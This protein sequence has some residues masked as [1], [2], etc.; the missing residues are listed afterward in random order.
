MK[1]RGSRLRRGGAL[2]RSLFRGQERDADLRANVRAFVDLLTDEKI[3]AG[4]TPEAARRAAILEC[5]SVDV[6][7]ENVRDVRAGALVAQVRQDARFALRILRCE[8][9]F[10]A[11]VILTLALGI[12]ANTAIFSV[13]NAVLLEPLPYPNAERLVLVWERNT[14][15][16][17]DR[18]PV[19][20]LNFQ[21]WRRS[22]TVFDELAAYRFRGVA[23]TH[24]EQPEQLQALSTTASLFRVLG[25]APALGRAFTDDEE[26]RRE[27][28]AVLSHAF[29]QR[30][31]GGDPSVVGR[32]VALDGAAFTIVGVMPAAF[33]FPDDTP[34][35]VDLYSPVAF[36]PRELNGR[37]V[38]TLTVMARLKPGVT[39]HAAQANIGTIATSIAAHDSTG[40]PEVAIVGAHDALVEDVRLGLLT[41]LGTVG[42]VLLV[43]CANVANLLLVRA[44]ARRRELAMRAALGAGNRRLLQQVLTESLV[45]AGLGAGVGLA[46]A[47][48]LLRMLVS[49]APPDL[50]RLERIA[51]DPTVLVFT[52]AVAIVT[53]VAFG[54]VP[55]LAAS[56]RSLTDVFKPGSPH[57]TATFGTSNGRTVLLVGEIALSL[58]LLAGA[59]LMV[60]SLINL[61]N[62]ELGLE[63]ANVLTAQIFLAPSRYPVDS[64][65][66]QPAPTG[67]SPVAESGLVVF[68]THLEERLNG[69]PGVEAVG[70]VSALPLNPVGIDYDLPVIIKGRPRPRAGEEP[71][72][73]FRV[74]TTGYFRTMHIPLLRG[75][76]FTDFDDLDSTPVIIINDTMAQHMFP[77]GD[78]IG[79]R[80]ILYGREGEIVGVVGSVRRHGFTRDARP[81]M[82]LPYRQF[83][84]RSMTLVVRSQMERAAIGAEVSRAVHA[85]DAQQPVHRVRMMAELVAASIAQPRFTTLLLSAFAALALVLAIVGIYG[86]MSYSVSQRT[87]EIGVRLALGARPREVV[88]MV[89]RRGM[90]IAAMGVALGLVGAAAATSLMTD[91]LFGVTPTDPATLGAACLALILSSLVATYVP[92]ARAATVAPASVLKGE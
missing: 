9:V 1:P 82:F 37:G 76:E 15:A 19:A 72:A 56:R 47:W 39:L 63:P 60:R 11:V 44:A 68:L 21:D 22:N 83:Q 8:P 79:Q 55:A 52:T 7:I 91:L 49:F 14:A 80:I 12:G 73:D 90:M 70:A 10:S 81:E 87:R 17:K 26:H 20:P 50:P 45:L 71:Q 46:L 75:R 57:T 28:V 53:G 6:V 3:A 51:I 24:V 29:W 2:L 62:V 34:V 41:L 85:L 67:A 25:V 35:P 31:F 61:Q 13:V 33:H 66:F 38:S 77:S 74:A 36:A 88:A 92:A 86:V 30:R 23:L 65:Q 69:A 18:D 48:S 5:G 84:L 27:R 42:L 4:M 54:L 16:G 89:V 32:S 58:T 59:G 43:A 78:P 64:A 40:N